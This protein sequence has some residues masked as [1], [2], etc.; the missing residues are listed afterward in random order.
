MADDSREDGSM[1][2]QF[3]LVSFETPESGTA[4]YRFKG[5]DSATLAAAV[6]AYLTQRGYKLEEGTPVY[7]AYGC[8]SSALRFLLGAFA[9]RFKFRVAIS[10]LKEIT[11]LDFSKAMSGTMGGAWGHVKMT[12]EYEKIREELKSL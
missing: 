11:T 2:S 10:S 3:N 8:G 4:R 1:A 6:A 7:G 12:K 5:T 9:K